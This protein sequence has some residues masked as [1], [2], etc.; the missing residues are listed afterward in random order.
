MAVACFSQGIELVTVY[1]TLGVDAVAFAL[2]QADAHAV[3]CERSLLAGLERVLPQ[4]SRMC[5]VVVIDDAEGA[6]D[7]TPRAG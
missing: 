4:L 1:A 6:S 3:V 7:A 2:R 5:H